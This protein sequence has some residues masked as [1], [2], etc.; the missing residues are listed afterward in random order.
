MRKED[1]YKILFD[2]E[3]FTCFA[4]T[5]FDTQR[6][7]HSA[8][9]SES[10]QWFSLN[11]LNGTRC[12]ANV[13]KHRNILVE[14]DSISIEMQKLTMRCL[15]VPWS[16]C[17]FSGSK[18]LHFIISLETVVSR[19]VYDSLVRRTIKVID[20]MDHS[21]KN[22]SRLTRC[23]NSINK[24]TGSIQHLLKVK[25]RISN[26]EFEKWLCSNGAFP[27]LT[28][29]QKSL[30][31]PPV[32]KRKDISFSVEKSFKQAHSRVLEG[33]R[34]Q[35]KAFPLEWKSGQHHMFLVSLVGMCKQF[36]INEIEFIEEFT[37]YYNLKDHEESHRTIKSIYSKK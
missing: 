15:E 32:F 30:L 16:T 21:V 6:Y 23:P 14:F 11:P 25:S 12:D 24:K 34:S 17:V 36:G 8:P 31:N 26:Q 2:E 18:S 35:G 37:K 29:E 7:H 1:F 9:I 10:A 22:P 3:D 4:K 28:E 33:K 20:G 13:T 5:N 19:E 27:E